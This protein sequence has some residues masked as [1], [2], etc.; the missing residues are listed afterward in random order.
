MGQVFGRAAAAGARG[1]IWYTLTDLLADPSR[2]NCADPYAWLSHGLLRSRYVAEAAAAC[3][4]PPLPGYRVNGDVEAKPS[5]QALS[6]AGR[7]LAGASFERRLDFAETGDLAVEAYRFR[8]PDGSAL[9]LAF[10]DHGERLGKRGQEDLTAEWVL[11]PA[12]LPG[13]TGRVRVTDYLGQVLQ[14]SGASIP[15]ALDHRPRY[16]EVAP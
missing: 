8:R 2:P 4:T 15:V 14:Q 3:P 6:T 11:T 12:L 13:W 1:A 7:L 16:V 5:W 9:L 10:T